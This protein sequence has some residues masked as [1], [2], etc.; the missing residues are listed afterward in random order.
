VT[1]P[2]ERLASSVAD[3]YRLGREL[4]QGGMA[5]VYLAEDLKH[6]RR[7]AIKVLHPEL[8]AAV[9]GERFLAEIKVTANLQHPHILPLFDS[10]AADGLLFYVMPLVEGESL[11]VKMS[12]EKELS[13]E[14][15]VRLAS[16]VLAALD[17]AHRHGVVH[18]DIKPENVLLHDGT[19]LVADFGIALA[20]SRAGASRLTATGMSLGTPA[21]MSPEQAMGNREVDAR[22]DIYSV[23]AMLY[24]MLVGDPPHVGSN[25]Q[26]IVAKVLT[27]K[28]VP[29]KAHRDTVP[30]NVAAAIQ[31]ALNKRPADRFA[32]AADFTKALATPGWT[33]GET[34]VTPLVSSVTAP[35]ARQVSRWR[36]VAI[37]AWTLVLVATGVAVRGWT[38]PAPL[39]PVTRYSMGIPA[40]QAMRQ[41][42]PGMNM[43]ISPDGRRIVYLGP[44]ESGDQFWLRERDRLDAT[45]LPGTIGAFNPA[46]SPDGSRI[47]FW[48]ATYTLKV[49]PIGGGPPVELAAPGSG[50]GGGAAWGPDGWIYFDNQPGLSR[51]R[52]DGGAVE[53]VAPIDSAGG[54]LGQAWPDVLP[55]GKGLLYRSRRSTVVGQYEIIAFDFATRTRRV[56]TKGI[57]ARYVAPG[58]LVVLRADGAVFAAPFDQD[59][60]A[61]TGPAVPLFEDVMIKAFGT[62]DLAISPSGTLAYVPGLASDAGGVAELV[63]VDRNGTVT[64]LAP[65]VTYNPSIYRGLS[66]SP[67]GTRIAL[68]VNGPSSSDVFT[69]RLP[70]GPLTRLTFSEQVEARPSWT[71]DGRDV[72]YLSAPAGGKAAAWRQRADGSSG[73]QRILDAPGATITQ[74][75]YSRDDTWLIYRADGT[76][77]LDLYAIRPG[78]DS[79]PTPLTAGAS[80]ALSPD[81][82]WLA[83]VTDESGRIEVIVRPFPN[84]AGGR[85]QVST[86]GGIGPRWARSG[87][88]LF[89]ES[90]SGDLMSVAVTAAPTF[91][92]GSP[93]RLFQLRAGLMGSGIL[94]PFYDVMPGDQRFVMVRLAAV[95]QAPGAGQLVVVDNW[96]TELETSM[97]A[98]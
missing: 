65:P 91:V 56:L 2:V 80:A 61:L 48:S 35:V 11:R 73:P 13:V 49:V 79:A 27:E 29:L 81:G 70:D 52:P 20:A 83:Y 78:R 36:R 16:Q 15:A 32:S 92:A 30:S 21:Y 85:W 6:D 55:N 10:G 94:L 5:T 38:R 37:G 64:P 53:V 12:R 28:P 72:V 74:A 69:M 88:E 34:L 26:A 41:D 3:R 98:K 24:E 25:A 60:F 54:E 8:S 51:V 58:Y 33:S 4:G 7:V 9:G 66:L 59:R 82:R 95:N 23:A 22:S 93:R 46:F 45:P 44:S 57:I 18:R 90:P 62:A 17:Y 87:R 76:D 84:V 89:Y 14:E 68:D 97:R 42:R 43:A 63:L 50:T 40:S 19:A 77:S 86:S 71:A 1:T 67:D 47:A 39:Q 31:K 75:F 96:L